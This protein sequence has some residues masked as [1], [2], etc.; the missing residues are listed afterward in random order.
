MSH[1]ISIQPQVSPIVARRISH[2]RRG[3]NLSH[4]FSQVYVAAGYT[5]A[6]FDAWITIKDIELIKSVG[7]DHVRFPIAPEPIINLNQPSQLPEQYIERLENRL[8]MILDSG[9]SVIVDI[10]PETPFKKTM[11]A[12]DDK[13]AA[14]IA[15]WEALAGRLSKFDSERVFFEVLNE[16]EI[17]DVKRWNK[18]QQEAAQAIRKA[19]PSHTIIIAGDEWSAL[20]MLHLVEPP[21]DRNIICNFHLY[22]PLAFTHQ[23][24]RWAPPWAMSCKGL[25]YPSDPAF[26]QDFLRNV[27]DP[28][29]IQALNEYQSLEWNAARYESMAA[30]AAAWGRE[31]GVAISCNEFGVYKV[32]AP[33]PSR[34]R[35]VGDMT[36]AFE[37]HDISWTM[38]DYAGD[39]EV[40]RRKDG[41]LVPDAEL[42]SALGLSPN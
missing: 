29:A 10:H 26:I 20:P 33:R 13:V 12:D 11:A 35:W 17:R 6:H 21:S 22:D 25:T 5:P 32:F 42:I 38:W 15:F 18:I 28:D 1:Q 8:Q 16:P 36:R 2:L 27:S 40:V 37:K 24:A 14:F 41:N 39:F 4:W 23:G 7:F 31:H 9:L 34:L 3:I 19:A 30:Q